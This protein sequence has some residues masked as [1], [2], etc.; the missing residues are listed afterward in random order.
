MTDN[1][2]DKL[3]NENLNYYQKNIDK[4]RT[5]NREYYEYR[6][7]VNPIVKKK[8]EYKTGEKIICKQ[9]GANVRKKYIRSHEKTGRCMNPYSAPLK[10]RHLINLRDKSDSDNEDYFTL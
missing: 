4:L 5:Y 7:V 8:Q 6:K 10:K 3:Y 2:E 9:C 1:Q